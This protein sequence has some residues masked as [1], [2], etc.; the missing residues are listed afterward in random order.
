MRVLAL[1]RYE[2]LGASSRV[3]MY[4]YIPY[5]AGHG[6]HVEASAFLCDDYVTRLY[7]GGSRGGRILDAYRRRLRVLRHIAQFDLIWIEKE[8]LPWMP[9]WAERRIERLRIPYIVDYDDATFHNYDSHRL[10]AVRAIL[11]RKIDE[12]MRRAAIVVAG[13]TYLAGR[14][15]TAKARRVEIVPTVVDLDH[16]PIEPREQNPT[17]TVGWIGTPVTA[18]Y[19]RV[20]ENGLAAVCRN[21]A[22]RLVTVGSG[23]IRLDGVPLEVRAWTEETEAAGMRCV[24]AGIMPL[25]DAPWERGK[26]GYKLIQY[27]ACAKPIV[28]SPVGVNCQIVD[29]EVNGFLA[30]STEEWERALFSLRD[31]AETRGRMGRAAREKVERLYSLQVT[32]PRM[33]ALFL[34]AVRP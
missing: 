31:D 25:P 33:L 23:P 14:A 6:I 4:Q 19:L 15:T 30:S 29:H 13:N 11:G 12:V 34:E 28:A 24:D 2:R 32:A 8:A 16:Y 27:M 1:P 20:A 21:G 17:F 9:A 22:A 3:R 26:C 18:P 5:L 10:P 7:S